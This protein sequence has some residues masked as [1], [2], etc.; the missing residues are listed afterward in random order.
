MRA[1]IKEIIMFAIRR[2]SKKKIVESG[3]KNRE[4]GKPIRDE[5]NDL[6][7]SKGKKH[8]PEVKEHYIVRTKNH[9]RGRSV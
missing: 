2:R 5:L 4:E 1:K 7:Y 3:F 9:H 8:Q 6:F